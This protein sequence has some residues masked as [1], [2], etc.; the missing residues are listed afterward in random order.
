MSLT[1]KAQQRFFNLT[2]EQVR[3]DSLLPVFTHHVPLGPTMP[4]P[5]ILFPLSIQNL[6]R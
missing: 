5:S 2:A 1:A 4:T 3:I 6:F